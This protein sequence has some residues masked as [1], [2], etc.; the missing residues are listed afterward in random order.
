MYASPSLILDFA[1]DSERFAMFRN[2]AANRR[3]EKACK[4]LIK[5][6]YLVITK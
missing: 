4:F 6:L 5:Q 1:S 3:Q 2:F